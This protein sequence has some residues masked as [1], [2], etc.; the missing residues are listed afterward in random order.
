[1]ESTSDS[2]DNIQ[3][4]CQENRKKIKRYKMGLY[5]NYEKSYKYNVSLRTSAIWK[6][7][8]IT[9]HCSTNGE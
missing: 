2:N 9:R 1:M 4:T 3:Q 6:A 5:K 8:G 7:L